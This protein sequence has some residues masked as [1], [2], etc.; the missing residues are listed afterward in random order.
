MSLGL[1]GGEGESGTKQTGGLKPQGLSC[2]QRRLRGLEELCLDSVSFILLDMP[3]STK[4]TCSEKLR[5]VS[6]NR[7]TI[8]NI[9]PLFKETHGKFF[10]EGGKVFLLSET[11]LNFCFSYLLILEFPPMRTMVSRIWSWAAGE[12]E[13]RGAP[14]SRQSWKTWIWVLAQL[15]SCPA[16]TT[17]LSLS[18]CSQ[19]HKTCPLYLQRACRS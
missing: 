12:H 10:W 9:F 18:P 19:G 8:R 5:Y 1:W 15:Y 7:I 13:W 4:R 17:S 11:T 6:V 3:G 2:Q 14:G 16:S